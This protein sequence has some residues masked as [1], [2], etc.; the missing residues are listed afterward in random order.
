MAGTTSFK[1]STSVRENLEQ[2]QSRQEAEKA[3][4]KNN[5]KKMTAFAQKVGKGVSNVGS[6]IGAL[7]VADT[8]EMASPNDITPSERKTME[9]TLELPNGV[10]NMLE[11]H[12]KSISEGKPSKMLSW[13]NCADKL[14]VPALIKAWQSGLIKEDNERYQSVRDIQEKYEGVSKVDSTKVETVNV[15]KVVKKLPELVTDTTKDFLQSS[16][17]MAEAMANAGDYLIS[18]ESQLQGMFEASNMGMSKEEFDVSSTGI[19]HDASEDMDRQSRYG[20]MAEEFANQVRKNGFEQ[21]FNQAFS[22]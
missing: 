16:F 18:D 4:M 10:D 22:L 9:G 15:P 3:K 21:D 5:L 14:S 6:F 2:I 8:L 20:A 13:D 17:D 7:G 11:S 19:V 1:P 12:A